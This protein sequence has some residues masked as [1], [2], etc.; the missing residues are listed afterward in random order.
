MKKWVAGVDLGGTSI[1]IAFIDTMG[2]IIRKWQIPTDNR[3]E[4]KNITT[5]I[6]RTI[7]EKLTELGQTKEILE[8]IGM[9]AP[10]PVDYVNGILYNTVN[11]AWKDHYPLRDK[12][13][14]ELSLPVYI[15]NDANCAALGEMWKGA[16]AG[17]KDLVCVTLGTGVGGG[18]ITNGEIVQGISGSAGEIGHITSV[19][20]NGAP[21][22]CGKKGCLE[23]V[24]SATGIVRLATERLEK[25]RDN[26]G[27]LMKIFKVN[28]KIAA[29]D[30]F[31]CAREGD[32]L[33]LEVIEEVA[34]H[35]GLALANLGNTLNPVKIVI[36][37]G[38]SKAG[39]ILLDRVQAYFNEFAFSR[40]KESTKISIATLENDAGILGAG[41]L[42]VNRM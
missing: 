27:K 12:L 20:R 23:T 1:K 38:V 17:A 33:S 10:G 35:L 42:V 26:E 11:L 34:Y 18:I 39:N 2:T 4:G 14:K 8:G 36:G 19:S 5:D 29:K 16:G 30:V 41:W 40:V 31:D 13:E 37:G 15:E 28:G 3:E 6:A 32:E 25:E 21:C 9:G 22:N 24:A 7:E